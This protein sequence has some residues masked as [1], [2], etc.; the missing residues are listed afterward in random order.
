MLRL[1][2]T[3]FGHTVAEVRSAARNLA[4]DARGLVIVSS[5]EGATDFRVIKLKEGL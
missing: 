5:L 2:P 3:K 1:T 4:D